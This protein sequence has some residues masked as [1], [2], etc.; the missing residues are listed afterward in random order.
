MRLMVQVEKWED[1]TE[2]GCGHKSFLKTIN[3]LP[4]LG[5]ERPNNC[6]PGYTWLAGK[7]FYITNDIETYINAATLCEIKGGRLYEP[8]DDVTYLILVRYLEV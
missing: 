6:P 1:I 2:K 8:R 4:F 3:F 5:I 7:C